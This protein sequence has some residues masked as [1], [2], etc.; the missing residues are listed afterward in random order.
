[1]KAYIYTM[2]IAMMG[3]GAVTAQTSIKEVKSEVMDEELLKN[4]KK[5][6]TT[7]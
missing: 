1:M 7:N 3:F 5:K 6:K 4:W 2:I